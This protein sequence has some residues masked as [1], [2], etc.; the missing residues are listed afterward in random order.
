MSTAPRALVMIHGTR[1]SRTQFDPQRAALEGAG[2]LVRTPDLPGHGARL[3][4]PLTRESASATIH[5]A[6]REAAA[7][8]ERV[9]LMG[10]SLGGMLA[11]HAAATS[12]IPLAGLI[13][14]GCTATPWALAARGYGGL[15][16]TLGRAPD[17][18]FARLIGEEGRRTFDAGG[19]A[20]TA[21]VSAAMRSVGGLDLLGDLRGLE[22]PVTFLNGRRDQFRLMERRFLR[23]ARRGRLVIIPAGSH[24]VNL[25]HPELVTAAI[26]AAIRWAERG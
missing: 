12:P 9:H 18:A 25:T 7:E 2:I 23:A 5:E 13:A 1:T 14:A 26:L 8:A 6:L 20:S 15:L 17:A 19:R 21:T 22:V 3:T 16:N 11:I 24:L 4:E 10:H